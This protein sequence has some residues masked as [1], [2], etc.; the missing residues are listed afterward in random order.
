MTRD[1]LTT[2]R[3]RLSRASSLAGT[4][5]LVLVLGAALTAC[6][7]EN[8]GMG[9]EPPSTAGS[10]NDQNLMA[11]DNPIELN[12]GD[13]FDGQELVLSASSSD[14]GVATA[15]VSDTTLTV[16][17]QNGGSADVT[18]TAENDAGTAEQ[19]F[20]VNVDLPDGPAP[21]AP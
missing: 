14:A 17:P 18:V 6:G 20:T 9:L 15:S 5:L 4:A 3:H 7:D 16:D 21:P 13:V 12:V 19:A 2:L 11:D 10:I 8:G 1:S